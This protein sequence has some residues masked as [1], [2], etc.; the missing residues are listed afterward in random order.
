VL[1]ST[2]ALVV[3]D[4]VRFKII[5]GVAAEA[6]LK[7]SDYRISFFISL[8][9]SRRAT[10]IITNHFPTNARSLRSYDARVAASAYATPRAYNLYSLRSCRYHS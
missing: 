8:E 6:S 3:T 9:Q 4:E 5:S 2:H 1:V 7:E 10:V